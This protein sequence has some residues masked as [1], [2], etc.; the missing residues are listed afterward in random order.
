[1]SA[2]APTPT[3]ATQATLI[4]DVVDPRRRITPSAN[5]RTAVSGIGGRLYYWEYMERVRKSMKW[6]VPSVAM[7]KD[8]WHG[9][10]V[11]ICGGGPSLKA[12]VP[13]IRELQR[14]GGYVVTV[15][16]THDHFL[17]PEWL[18]TCA[19]RDPTP[20]IP[21]GHVV[22][23]PMPWV[24]DYIKKPTTTTKYFVASS[25]ESS[26]MRRLRLGGGHC[27]L[28]HAGADFYGVAMPEPVLRAEFPRKPW[29]M[30]VGPTTVG[31][32]S[33]VLMYD[34]GFRPFHLFG[35]DSSMAKVNGEFRLHAYDK[36]RPEDSTEG[37]VT[38]HTKIG[39]Y[40]FYTNDHMS[41]Q[42]IDFEDLCEQI[43]AHVMAGRWEPVDI[44][45]H[46]DGLLPCYAASIG[47]HADEKM[48]AEFQGRIA[49]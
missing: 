13:A 4:S 26:V 5:L 32:R 45:V 27:Y 18:A 29:G 34:L 3:P 36:P 40:S 49:A 30:V 16:K 6:D 9:K 39:D 43:G 44:R 25:C 31:L 11:L 33:V 2:Q 22:L 14:R 19:G 38:L 17:D 28:W 10:A 42:V 12:S 23:D 46:G 21:W 37:L 8:A 20:I 41:R 47:L 7:V 1:M 24:A 15:N 35:F 48:N